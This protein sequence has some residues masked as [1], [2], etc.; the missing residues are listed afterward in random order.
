MPKVAAAPAR[1]RAAKKAA[2]PTDIGEAIVLKT[3]K[4]DDADDVVEAEVV[5]DNE[6]ELWFAPVDDS[7]DYLNALFYGR[8]GST[9]TTSAARMANLGRT[10]FINAEGGLKV[11][12]LRRQGV[13][14]DNLMVWP[15]PGTN[16]KITHR[17]LDKLYRNVKADLAKDPESWVCIVFDSITEV[18]QAV[19]DD[20]QQARVRKIKD[21]GGDPD[22]YFVD[23][24]DYGTMSKMVR[25]LLRKFRDLPCHVIFTA[26]ERRDVDQQ[27]KK[28]QYGPAITPALQAD[29]LG[30]PDLVLMFKA[31]D[32]VGPA[33]AL[34]RSNSQYR[35]K[36]RF[37][38]L[39]RVLAQPTA[40]RIIGYI[41]GT[42]TEDEDP[43]QD[44]LSI[45]AKKSQDAKAITSGK[46]D[47]DDSDS[48]EDD[49]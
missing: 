8:E 28:A 42:L 39:P 24:A 40:D 13:D 9:K 16:A 4:D 7:I 36:D 47:E 23:I 35:A 29:I 37:G 10:L 33:R 41:E 5:S 19:L 31:P 3:G 44:D 30:Y 2:A 27:T 32:E 49:E 20:V 26:L 18:Y 6:V 22:E 11:K 25:D 45:A 34:T 21:K 1:K 46:D 17:N 12:A 43:F 38:V 48:D 14:T 15:R